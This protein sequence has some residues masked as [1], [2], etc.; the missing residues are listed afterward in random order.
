MQYGKVMWWEKE[1]LLMQ[2]GHVTHTCDLKCAFPEVTSELRLE[3]WVG[4]IR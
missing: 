1:S 3:G 4:I 2:E